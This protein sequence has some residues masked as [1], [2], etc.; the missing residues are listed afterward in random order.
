M[1][2]EIV[3]VS[4]SPRRIELLKRIVSFFKVVKPA[5]DD[6]SQSSFP[7]E[8]A[9]RKLNSVE[10]K[11]GIIYISADTAV[12][13]DGVIL[14][15]PADREDAKRMLKLLSGKWHTVE[16]AVVV[17][18]DD[19]ILEEVVRSEVRFRELMEDEIDFYLGTDEPYDKA[20]AYG[21]QGFAEVF[22]S[23][24][25][26]SYSNVVG[27]PLEATYRLLRKVGYRPVRYTTLGEFADIVR[28][29]NAG[30]F[31]MTFD[32]M[33]ADRD[34]YNYFKKGKFISRES[35]C[36]YM[37]IPLEDVIVFEYYDSAQA[38][39]ITVKRDPPSGS[40][41]D[42]DIYGATGYVRLLSYPIPLV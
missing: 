28:S 27:L 39:K 34:R 24:L 7:L 10:K 36:E 11:E 12:I 30:P 19:L 29:K 16:T 17:S 20:G 33:F 14:G 38:L 23:E 35:F 6:E 9:I 42:D 5:F 21:I 4:S 37:R 1:V 32:I 2:R 3:L 41:Y 22:V 15:K 25:K 18:L 40:I 26:G 31:M 13:V 8:N